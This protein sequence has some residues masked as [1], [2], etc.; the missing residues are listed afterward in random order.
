MLNFLLIMNIFLHLNFSMLIFSS[1][2]FV[3][4][5][6]SNSYVLFFNFLGD[7]KIEILAFLLLCF[8]RVYVIKKLQIAEFKY[9]R[10]FSEENKRNETK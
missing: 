4:S 1:L 8:L 6:L 7:N 10:I 5:V 3:F 9:T 2:F